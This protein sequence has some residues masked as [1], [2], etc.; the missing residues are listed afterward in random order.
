M[1]ITD[2]IGSPMLE[3]R[4]ID[5]VVRLEIEVFDWLVDSELAKGMES[6]SAHR[7]E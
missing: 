3:R 7:V 1:R 6:S 4:Y 2:E 5:G